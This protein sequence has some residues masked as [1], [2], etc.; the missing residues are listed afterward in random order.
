MSQFEAKEI[1]ARIA[2]A[3]RQAGLNQDEFAEMAPFSLRSLQDYE[4]GKTIPYRQMRDISKLLG[5]PVEWFLHGEAE[6]AP[7]LLEHL[8]AIDQK[9]ESIDRK[10]DVMDVGGEIAALRG[11][12]AE[13][14]AAIRLQA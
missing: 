1:G 7:A 11:Q 3:R 6:D 13:L 2:Q 10:L 8:Q 14:A 12:M 9:L 5:K 4:Q